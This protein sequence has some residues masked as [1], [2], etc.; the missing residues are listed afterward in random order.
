MSNETAD[1]ESNSNFLEKAN[2]I[3]SEDV[4][5]TSRRNFANETIPESPRTMSHDAGAAAP[6]DTYLQPNKTHMEA[7]K[8]PDHSSHSSNDHG[9]VDSLGSAKSDPIV[10]SDITNTTKTT[11]HSA[12]QNNM[13]TTGPGKNMGTTCA[14]KPEKASARGHPAS[15]S[16]ADKVQK[17]NAGSGSSIKTRPVPSVIASQPESIK[18]KNQT[19]AGFVKP[20]PKSPTKPVRLP[21]SLTAPTAS[22]VSKVHGS[23]QSSSHQAGNRNDSAQT[24]VRM[25]SSNSGALQSAVKRQG[26]TASRARPSLGLPPTKQA[27]PTASQKRQSNVDEGF[28]ARM[29]R[30]TQSSSSKATDKAPVTPPKKAS[31][32]PVGSEHSTQ[33][34]PRSGSSR[35]LYKQSAMGTGSSKLTLTQQAETAE[36]VMQ[37]KLKHSP[38]ELAVDS[39][40]PPE[41]AEVQRDANKEMPVGTLNE[42]AAP[43]PPGQDTT[44]AKNMLTEPEELSRSETPT[45]GHSLGTSLSMDD[46]VFQTKRVHPQEGL[47]AETTGSDETIGQNEQQVPA[48][49]HEDRAQETLSTEKLLHDTK[50]TEGKE[51]IFEEPIQDAVVDVEESTMTEGSRETV[52]AE[53]DP[54]NTST[55]EKSIPQLDIVDVQNQ[56]PPQE[57][58]SPQTGFVPE[59]ARHLPLEKK[60]PEATVEDLHAL[61]GAEENIAGQTETDIQNPVNGSPIDN[62][63]VAEGSEVDN[64]RSPVL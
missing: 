64:S 30:P 42:G 26:S 13:T 29:M 44:K 22:S 59:I 7:K 62:M 41:R 16:F 40:V 56:S 11:G 1:T 39:K 3:S 58:E 49:R 45:S 61:T 51:Q 33:A 63:D 55:L 43:L 2:T 38:S 28:L 23:R 48:E 19:D 35:G 8:Q 9:G 37:P 57:L 6:V 12:S 53:A 52:L 5:K 20:K 4:N 24:S 31:Q 47:K 25:N 15:K 34:L 10:V 32:R 14:P 46:A 21:S 18:I 60:Q 27:I 17:P 54:V 50:P 36:E